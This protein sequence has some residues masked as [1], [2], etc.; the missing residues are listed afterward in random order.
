MR[1]L[2]FVFVAGLFWLSIPTIHA[3]SQACILS[4][5]IETVV[6]GLPATDPAFVLDILP[7]GE[8]YQ[9]SAF[10]N[11]HYYIHS[12]N[13]T[14][15]GW[16]DQRSASFLQGNCD[17]LP[18]PY[19]NLVDFID[20][21]TWTAYTRTEAIDHGQV[22]N[23]FE[24]GDSFLVTRRTLN[25]RVALFIDSS[26]FSGYVPVHNGALRGNCD[27]IP[28][29][30]TFSVTEN[31]R[32]WSLPDVYIGEIVAHLP[33][34]EPI[35]VLVGNPINGLITTG[36][37]GEWLFAE[38]AGVASG[39]IWVERLQDLP[40]SETTTITATENTRLWSAPDV[41]T[42]EVIFNIPEGTALT[43]LGNNFV[44][45]AI[46]STVEGWWVNVSLPSGLAGWVWI[47]RINGLALDH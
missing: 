38:Y 11:S 45:G 6:Y 35:S 18:A 25:N 34:D 17:N 16:I 4:T 26:R 5:G 9:T 2:I 39:W 8:T 33:A 22:V 21:C 36:V 14:V 40:E 15:R 42:G 1:F 3:Q 7:V 28:T 41:T 32:L 30:Q 24:A 31:A 12:V 27:L 19:D 13:D 23:T 44:W 46:T 29:E 47:E 20:V 37:E 43:I 10:M